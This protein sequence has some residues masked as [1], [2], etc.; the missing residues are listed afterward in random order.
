MTDRV[1]P[2]FPRVPYSVGRILL[3]EERVLVITQHPIALCLPLS[4]ALGGLV[5]AIAV[6]QIPGIAVSAQFTVWAL[7]AFLMMRLVVAVL[8]W[9]RRRIVM[10]DR[11]LIVVPGIFFGKPISSPPPQSAEVA[12]RR[13]LFGRLFKYATYTFSP[14][15]GTTSTFYF[16][17]SKY[18]DKINEFLST[19]ENDNGDC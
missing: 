4:E 3:S 14:A 11:R 10:T 9:P 8:S 16:I 19:E 13:P 1:P 2:P 18:D 7:V 15:G 6:S 17:P 5:A 12:A